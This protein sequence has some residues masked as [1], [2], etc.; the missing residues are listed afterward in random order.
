MENT[1][2]FF[3]QSFQQ[4]LGT[5]AYGTGALANEAHDAKD[6]KLNLQVK[7]L[8]QLLHQEKAAPELLPYQP[9]L[10]TQITKKINNQET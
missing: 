10:I 6:Y 3:S 1:S 5:N 9:V 4:K 2:S 8:Q 7:Q